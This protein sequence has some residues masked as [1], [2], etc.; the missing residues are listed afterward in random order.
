MVIDISRAAF[1]QVEERLEIRD[2]DKPQAIEKLDALDK[3][4]AF[5]SLQRPYDPDGPLFIDY[6]E[7]LNAYAGSDRAPVTHDPV[8]Y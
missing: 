6:E 5:A 7:H 2:L 4:I 3:S 1:R 8:R